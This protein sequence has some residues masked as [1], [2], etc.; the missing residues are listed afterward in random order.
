METNTLRILC[1]SE[2][3]GR[4]ENGERMTHRGF[5]FT[6]FYFLKKYPKNIYIY[7]QSE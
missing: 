7:I 3:W 6:V 2:E 1:A 5:N 4:G